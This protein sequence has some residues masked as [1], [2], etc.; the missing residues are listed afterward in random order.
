MSKFYKVY[1]KGYRVVPA[2]DVAEALELAEE[3]SDWIEERIDVDEY[4]VEEL[5][6]EDVLL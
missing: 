5:D 3:G 2:E 1:F 6:E 4:T